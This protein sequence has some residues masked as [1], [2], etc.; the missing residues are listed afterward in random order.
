MMLLDPALEGEHQ[1]VM[2][3]AQLP[4]GETSDLLGCSVALA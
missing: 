2:L 3:A 1:L 4:L